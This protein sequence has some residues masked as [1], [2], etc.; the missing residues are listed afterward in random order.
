MVPLLPIVVTGMTEPSI[1]YISGALKWFVPCP[2]P[3][4]RVDRSLTV[5]DASV[6]ITMIIVFVLTS[7]LFW[8]SSNYPKRTVQIDSKNLQ[9]IPKCMYNAWSIF[10]GVS[11]PEMPRSWKVRI[12][13][14]IYVCYC[15][16]ISTVFQA[17]FVSYLV[18]PGYGE[19]MSSFWE[20]LDSEVNYGFVSSIEVGMRTMEYSDH[21][22]FPLTRRVDCANLK[23]CLLRMMSDGDVATLSSESYS[24]YIFNELGYQGEIKPPCSLDENF[25]NLNAV[26]VFFRGNPMLN[27]FNKL[28]RRC[29]E[30]GLGLKYWAQLNHEALLRGRTKSGLDGSS[31]YFVFT[32]SHMIPA[33]SV[34]GFG[35]LCSTLLLIAE[36]LHK[37]FSK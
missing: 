4:S 32:M 29:L 22:Q 5:F 18:E 26:S 17:F 15:F 11:V 35:Y 2:K 27:Q 16:A 31:M 13:F 37:R 23:T 3:I 30:G 6:W 34:L 28:I 14:L 21:L 20:L 36:G 10:I 7:A 25:I 33:F 24:N 8:F 1:P 9:T 12:L 19:K